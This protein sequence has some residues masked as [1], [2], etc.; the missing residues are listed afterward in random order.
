MRIGTV[1]RVWLVA[2]AGLVTS[3]AVVGGYAASADRL[4][5]RPAVGS[6]WGLVIGMPVVWIVLG[7]GVAAVRFLVHPWTARRWAVAAALG[8]ALFL[9]LQVGVL[10]GGDLVPV[11]VWWLSPPAVVVGALAGGAVGWWAAGPD[12]A[13]PVAAVGPGPAAVR[14]RLLPDERAVWTRSVV[15]R[16]RLWQAGGWTAAVVLLTWVNGHLPAVYLVP[17]VVVLVVLVAQGWARVRVDGHGVRVEQPLLRRTLVGVDLAHVTGAA[18]E[19]V[20]PRSL[21]PVF[22]VLN[23]E[24]VWGFR[25]TGGGEL[26][27]TATSDGRDFVVTVPDAETAAALVNAELDRRGAPAC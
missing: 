15:C 21:P 9:A 3:A 24:R 26:L 1:R 13:L 2:G 5:A 7:C 8:W 22:G 6:S 20:G 17:S 11:P 12:P 4:A 18:A 10:I 16:R 23:A 27:R 25:A 14:M 19:V